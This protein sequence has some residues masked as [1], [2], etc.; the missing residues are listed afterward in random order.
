MHREK[1]AKQSPIRG[2]HLGDWRG[3]PATGRRV[4]FALC[5]VYTFDAQDRLA[6]EKIYYARGT[7]RGNSASFMSRKAH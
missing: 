3:L 5:G 6:E 2:T 7:V 4:E 1:L